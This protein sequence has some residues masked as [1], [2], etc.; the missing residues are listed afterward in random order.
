MSGIPIGLLDELTWV[1]IA[2]A[3]IEA[4]EYEDERREQ[5]HRAWLAQRDQKKLAIQAALKVG[6][7]RK[8]TQV[9]L[10]YRTLSPP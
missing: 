10:S 6:S 8:N 3:Q 7:Y 1:D 5:E 9:E 4:E 2:H